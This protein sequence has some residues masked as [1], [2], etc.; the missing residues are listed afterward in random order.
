MI[1]IS[2]RDY[3][4]DILIALSQ[5]IYGEDRTKERRKSKCVRLLIH[6]R[7][8]YDMV[9]SFGITKKKSETL[10]VNLD[11]IPPQHFH[12]FLRGYIDGDG[13]YYVGYPKKGYFANR[14]TICGN[15]Y[16]MSSFV[17]YV[18]KYYDLKSYCYPDRTSPASFP[19]YH[20]TIQKKTDTVKLLN[21]LYGGATL[22]LQRKFN[23][24][25]SLL[26]SAVQA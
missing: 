22:Y 8:I 3:D 19:F 10:K 17:K 18:Q 16:M 2:L 1:D 25:S 7:E 20:W 26:N 12:H 6:G 14:I 15:H 9:L 4:K 11:Q 13:S 5:A 23:T 21:Y 24:I